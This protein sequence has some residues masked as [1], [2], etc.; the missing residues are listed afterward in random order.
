VPIWIKSHFKEQY[1]IELAFILLEH[2][3]EIDP[4]IKRSLPIGVHTWFMMIHDMN[5]CRRPLTM[6]NSDEWSYHQLKVEEP[7]QGAEYNVERLPEEMV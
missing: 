7:S 3:F 6:A 2:W 1:G 4:S 5:Q